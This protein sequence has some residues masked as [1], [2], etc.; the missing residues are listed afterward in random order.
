MAICLASEVA[1]THMPADNSRRM[2]RPPLDRDSDTKLTGVRLTA[3]VRRRI[4]AV[5]GKHRMAA[6]IREAIEHELE[7]REIKDAHGD[8]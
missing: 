4:E 5:V 3:D 6:F 1:L 7:R 2:G 8:A